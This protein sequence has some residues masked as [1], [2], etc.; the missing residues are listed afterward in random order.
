MP[1][2]RHHPESLWSQLVV[3][4]GLTGRTLLG[5]HERYDTFSLGYVGTKY[6][7]GKPSEI[8]TLVPENAASIES[9]LRRVD[10]YH[11][12]S[13]NEMRH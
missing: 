11:R 3:P 1:E 2:Y 5:I 12:Y 9:A 7:D 4:F 8:T 13:G 6:I 10:E